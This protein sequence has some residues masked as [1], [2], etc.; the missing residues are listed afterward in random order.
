[1]IH[2]R[3]G[4][5]TE[6]RLTNASPRRVEEL[7]AYLQQLQLAVGRIEVVKVRENTPFDAR[8]FAWICNVFNDPIQTLEYGYRLF[9]R[10]C[11]HQTLN[12]KS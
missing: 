8:A 11:K 2:S 9:F 4:D 12:L 10:H 3:N 5:F 7:L 1:M 6:E